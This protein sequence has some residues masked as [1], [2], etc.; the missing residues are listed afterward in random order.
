MFSEAG[1]DLS[2]ILSDLIQSGKLADSIRLTRVLEESVR[3]TAL[4]QHP[5]GR[6]LGVKKA[7]FY[8]L[9]GAHMP[10]SLLELLFIDN[11]GDAQ[12]L[13][14][15]AFRELLAQ[16]VADGVLRFLRGEQ[17]RTTPRMTRAHPS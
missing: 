15:P 13:Q 2:F 11:Q 4:S 1:D 16:S 14:D 3:L 12:R 9:V 17:A 5:M 7:P 10:C 6:S 8:V